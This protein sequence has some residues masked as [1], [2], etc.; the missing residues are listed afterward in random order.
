MRRPGPET[1]SRPSLIEAMPDTVKRH[2]QLLRPTRQQ[3]AL[4]LALALLPVIWW[5][6]RSCS[7][8]LACAPGPRCG[9]GIV[10]KVFLLLLLLVVIFPATVLH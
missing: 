5:R 3:L 7:A 1:R 8:P 4:A 6:W 10:S 2:G 9:S